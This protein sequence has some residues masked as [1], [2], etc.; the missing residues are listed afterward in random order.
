M[1]PVHLR[2]EKAVICVTCSESIQ[3]NKPFVCV[4]KYY[5]KP[6]FT[7]RCWNE[8]IIQ[9]LKNW[10]CN[11]K[12][13][14]RFPQRRFSFVQGCMS[15]IIQPSCSQMQDGS[16]IIEK[17]REM[18]FHGNAISF[19]FTPAWRHIRLPGKPL[20]QRCVCTEENRGG[21]ECK[22]GLQR[23]IFTVNVVKVAWIIYWL[24]RHVATS[25]FSTLACLI[26]LCVLHLSYLLC[27]IYNCY[28]KI[29]TFRF[30]IYNGIHSN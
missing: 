30:V 26:L 20:A 28:S 12:C 18:G 21:N 23:S 25:C 5:C 29:I 8:L 16:E 17:L 7:T 3:H 2:K 6:L 11:L 24:S 10:C 14:S 27:F 22:N 19:S 13:L 9:R 4:N 15:T 1:R